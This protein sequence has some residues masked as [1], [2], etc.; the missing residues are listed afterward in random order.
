MA[1][2]FRTITLVVILTATSAGGASLSSADSSRSGAYLSSR[3]I[4]SRVRTTTP[5]VQ[6][7]SEVEPLGDAE[8]ALVDWATDRFAQAGLELPELTVRFDPTREL[9]YYNEGRYHHAP[10][11]DRVRSEEHT[12][13]LQSH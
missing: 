1:H 2:I 9:C 11:G 4:E 6:T 12:S 3:I 7:V 5:V 13:E 8:Q 10:N